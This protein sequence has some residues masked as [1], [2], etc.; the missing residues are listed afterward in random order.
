MVS[1]KTKFEWVPSIGGSTYVLGWYH[2]AKLY[3]FQVTY[4]TLLPDS[5]SQ[6]SS[7]YMCDKHAV[8]I[9]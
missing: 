2:F 6:L 7:S 4:V 9:E 8:I 1:L 3:L 5:Q